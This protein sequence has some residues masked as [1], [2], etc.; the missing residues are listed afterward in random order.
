MADMGAEIIKIEPPGTGDSSRQSGPRLPG[1]DDNLFFQ[2]FNRSKRSLTLNLKTGDGQRILRELAVT[3]DAV[4]NNLRGDLPARLGLTYS[5]L[6]DIKRSLVC[7]HL[8]GYGRVGPRAAW[9][10]YDYLMQAEAGFMDLTGSP[11]GEPT[12]MGLSIIDYLS[13]ITAAFSLTAAILGAAR[14]GQGRDVDVT[15]YDVAMHQLTYPAAWYL[16]ARVETRRRPRSGHPSVVPCEMI[17]TSDGHVFIMC[18]LPKFWEALCHA[19]GLPELITDARFAAPQDRRENRDAL[20]DLLDAAFAQTT[21]EEWMRRLV[22]RVPVAPVLT[23]GAALDS[24]YARE[25]G[26]IETIDHHA[27]PEDLSFVAS[28]IRLDGTRLVSGSAP[29]LGADTDAVLGELGYNARDIGDLRAAG[30]I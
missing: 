9:P 13:G 21:T 18:V 12:R 19:T 26:V 23:M 17:P 28:P 8:S 24:P 30:V 16:N 2:T 7:L 25:S 3:A 14:S 6:A 11:G 27:E 4:M 20:M 5:D 29:A 1:E 10:A 15:L 22:G